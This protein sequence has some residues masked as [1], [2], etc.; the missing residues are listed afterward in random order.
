V[1]NLTTP[2]YAARATFFKMIF[3]ETR[4]YVFIGI[5][6]VSME[7]HKERAFLWPDQQVEL[8][9]F[10]DSIAATTNVYYCPQI[11][12]SAERR[13]D[14]VLACPSAW[15]D[16]DECDPANILGATPSIILESSPDRYQALWLFEEDQEPDT[17]ENISKRIAYALA[18][19]GADKGGWDL[20]QLL[21]V[22]LTKN[23][24]YNDVVVKIVHSSTAVFRPSD[25]DVYPRVEGYDFLDIPFPE[26]LPEQP[27]ADIIREHRL[28]LN[29]TALT[30]FDT[31]PKYRKWS[32]ALWSLTMMLFEGGLTREQVYVVVRDAKCNK[33]A[34]DGRPKEALW[35]DVC[36]AYFKHQANISITKVDSSEEQHLL[37]DEEA[38]IAG[39]FDTWV[40]RYIRWA[41]SLGDAA[42]QY[43]QASAF[44]CLSAMIGSA[45]K[46]PTSFGTIAPN[47]WFM[48]L[49]D[50]TITR[51]STAMDIGMDLLMEIREETLLATDGS[52]EG[53]FAALATRPGI[54]S[55]FLRDEFSGL[56]EQMTKRDYMAGFAEMLTK[57]YDGKV[58]KRLLRKETIIIKEPHLILYC[59]GIKTRIQELLTM[60]QVSSGF[61]PRFIFITAESDMTRVRPLGPPTSVNLD[62][63]VSIL[64][65]L[66]DIS[67]YYDEQETIIVNGKVV[68]SPNKRIWKAELTEAA[69]LRY[70]E[71]ESLLMRTGMATSQPDVYTPVYDRLGKSILKIAVLLAASR[72]RKDTVV[73]ELRDMLHAI[74]YGEGWRAYAREVITNVGQSSDE[75]R[76]MRI[77]TAIKKSEGIS[78]SA[79]MQAHHLAARDA[80]HLF[81]TLEQ[82][83]LITRFRQGRGEMLLPTDGS[84]KR[85]KQP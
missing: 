30:L 60:D 12:K 58:Q 62:A 64:D 85:E 69:W 75:K 9:E 83:G 33:F 35:K 45:V 84:M 23:H 7:Q 10:I 81:E 13:K 28:R 57:L 6:D 46:L 80:N 26:T 70:N 54:P 63:R 72:Q 68:I 1:V 17:A 8:L 79:L 24:K 31:V 47:V 21:R 20:S 37:T 14:N 2:Y 50:T 65:E 15:A 3:G 71:L 42:H 29:A 25:F 82:R 56:L 11:F 34:R 48:L 41:K 49:A 39:E 38:S 40:E 27:G 51:K 22:P 36:R 32:L 74:F 61:L 16:L 5:K 52:L 4:G 19:H 18:E 67:Q 73:V 53:M 44:V 78:R 77:Y 55:I 76:L 59:G 43:H 66:R